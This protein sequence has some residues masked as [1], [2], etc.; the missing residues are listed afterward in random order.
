MRLAS[1]LLGL[2]FLFISFEGWAEPWM[3]NRF[4]QNCAACHAP[5]RLNRKPAKRRCT[6]SCQGCH[7]NPNGGGLRNSYGKWNSERWVRSFYTDLTWGKKSPSPLKK[8]RYHKDRISKLNPKQLKK[9]ARKGAKLVGFKGVVKN[10][11]PY[12]ESSN[13]TAAKNMV[14][15]LS[16][17]TRN[18]PYRL[19]RRNQVTVGG[20]LR[21]FFVQQSKGARSEKLEE[22]TFFPMAFDFGVRVR[23][24]KEKLSLVYE[25]RALNT[26]TTNPS[27]V[28]NLFAGG[29]VTRSAYI[30]VDDLWYNSYVQYGFYRPMFGLYNPNHLAMTSDYTQ[31]TVRTRLKG[32][33]IGAAPNVPFGIVNVIL[34]TENGSGI[35]REAGYVATLG[36][37]FVRYGAHAQASLWS[38]QDDDAATPI[39][40]DMWNI[41]VGAKL[42]RFIVNGELTSVQREASR[43]DET[44]IL[45]VEGRFRVWREMYLQAMF[46]Q[47]NAS[48]ANT[49]SPNAI[50]GIAPGSGQEIAFGFRAFTISGLE[51]ETLMATKTYK[52]DNFPDLTTETLTL[53]MH[54]YF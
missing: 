17:I 37:R 2:S 10:E 44:K 31:F 1:I 47:A 36:M 15:E 23:P 27:S 22:G 13:Y 54:A 49:G 20:D 9:M 8:Q 26:N 29:A 14:E 40:R 42:G 28:D 18:D 30:M 33:G 35:E 43:L 38:T 46:T 3:A 32:F 11:K 39:K 51:F 50:T 53:Q 41:N 19:E 45:G 7:V 12:E 48:L 24:I 34:P 25:G 4:A 52:E 21:L 5:G 6:L 16:R